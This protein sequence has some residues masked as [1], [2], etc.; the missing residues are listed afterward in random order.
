MN[1][2]NYLNVFQYKCQRSDHVGVHPVHEDIIGEDGLDS[3]HVR[4]IY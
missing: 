2:V 1:V 3:D 4:V